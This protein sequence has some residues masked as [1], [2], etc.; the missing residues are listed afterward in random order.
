MHYLHFHHLLQGASQSIESA[1]EVYK[2][3]EG[4]RENYFHSRKIKIRQVNSRSTLNHFAFH[5][6]N[7]M[8]TFARNL[9]LKYLVNK[10]IFRKLSR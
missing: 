1:Y 3:I 7:P 2:N 4:K 8:I 9:S 6:S 5:A 10:N